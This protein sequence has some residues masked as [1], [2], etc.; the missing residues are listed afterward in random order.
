MQSYQ[1]LLKAL[2]INNYIFVEGLQK[3]NEEDNISKQKSFIDYSCSQLLSVFQIFAF[4][5]FFF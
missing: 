1:P 3:Q 2:S 4:V 5:V